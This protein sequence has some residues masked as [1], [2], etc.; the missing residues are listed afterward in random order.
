MM[1]NSLYTTIPHEQ[2]YPTIR[3][4]DEEMMDYMNEY[5]PVNP[6]PEVDLFH[7]QHGIDTAFISSGYN[8]QT[9]SRPRENNIFKGYTYG[10][11]TPKKELDFLLPV[12]TDMGINFTVKNGM[13]ARADGKRSHKTFAFVEFKNGIDDYY[14]LYNNRNQI[15]VLIGDDSL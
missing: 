8:V 6:E 2:E 7:V 4:P 3:T 12:L 1:D 14:R 15:P 10:V 5:A 13:F 11:E 9:T